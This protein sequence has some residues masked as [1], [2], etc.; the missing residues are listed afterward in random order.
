[1]LFSIISLLFILSFLICPVAAIVAVWTFN[2]TAL[3]VALT[4][5]IILMFTNTLLENNIGI[6]EGEDV[7]E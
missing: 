1:M 6:S 4:A 2:Q 3:Q 7:S 5:G